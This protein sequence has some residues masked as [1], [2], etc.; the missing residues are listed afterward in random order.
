VLHHVWAQWFC[1]P[2]QEVSDRQKSRATYHTWSEVYK[3]ELRHSLASKEISCRL[4]SALVFLPVC[5][6]RSTLDHERLDI[7]PYES[8][9]SDSAISS[10]TGLEYNFTCGDIAAA[11]TGLMVVRRW[12]R[13]RACGIDKLDLS[14]HSLDTHTTRLAVE[15][16]FCCEKKVPSTQICRRPPAWSYSSVFMLS[17]E[18]I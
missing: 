17:T 2:K 5:L 8:T 11:D 15:S 13:S 7:L 9:A 4:L 18:C 3:H 16:G 14:S 6:Q 12:F 10:A 1:Y